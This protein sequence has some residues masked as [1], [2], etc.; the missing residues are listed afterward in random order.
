MASICCSPPESVP[1]GAP[2]R[3]PSTG[4]RAYCS[5]MEARRSG[6]G[7][8]RGQRVAVGPAATLAADARVR[9][10]YLGGDVA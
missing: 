8:A 9:A 1:A 6:R 3:S 10:A 4:K 7:S 2:R 5:S